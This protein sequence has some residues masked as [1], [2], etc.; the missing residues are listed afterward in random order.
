MK[1]LLLLLFLIPNL[2]MGEEIL[3]KYICT[4][5]EQS[6]VCNKGCKLDIFLGEFKI[7]VKKDLVLRTS[8][9]ASDPE[10]PIQ[11]PYYLDNCKVLDENNWKCINSTAA[12]KLTQTIV[13]RNGIVSSNLRGP[14]FEK[15]TCYK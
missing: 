14:G 6:Y 4:T 11:V 7:N 3:N 13:S 1:K 2:V 12:G 9:S 8:F 10:S 5:A 15:Y